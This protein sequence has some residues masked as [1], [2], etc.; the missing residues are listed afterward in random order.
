MGKLLLTGGLFQENQVS[1]YGGGLWVNSTLVLTGTQF[2]SNTA[3]AG[4]GVWANEV[5]TVSNALFQA[6]QAATGAGLYAT[7]PLTLTATQFMS[8]TAAGSNDVAGA[9]TQLRMLQSLPGSSRVTRP[10]PMAAGCLVITT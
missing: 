10:A 4:G 6:N 7:S 5:S 1:A 3:G 9:Y 8:N 2:L